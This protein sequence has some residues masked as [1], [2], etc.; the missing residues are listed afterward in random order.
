MKSSDPNPKLPAWIFIA[1]DLALI[2]AAVLIAVASPQPLSGSAVLWIVACV[3]LGAIAGLVPLVII[4]EQ[5]KNELLDDRQRAL[6]ALARTVHSSAEQISIAANGLHQISELALKNLRMAEHLPHKLQEKIAEF[7][8]QLAVAADAEKEELEREL[9]SLRTSESERLESVSQRIAKTTAEWTKLEAASNQHLTAANETATRLGASLAG[10]IAKAQSAAEHALAQARVDAARS[11]GESGGQAVRALEAAKA[12]AMVEFDTK[13]ATAAA[14]VAERISAELATRL[15]ALPAP[16]PAAIAPKSTP[17]VAP[18]EPA[19]EPIVASSPVAAERP[20][21]VVAAEPD[22]SSAPP[23]APEPDAPVSPTPKRPR[24]PRRE[25]P[26]PVAPEAVVTASPGEEPPPVPAEAIPEITPIAPPTAEPFSG[27]IATVPP[28][29]PPAPAVESVRPPANTASPARES[30][31]RN[32]RVEPVD[33][34]PALGLGLEETSGGSV[35]EGVLTSDGATRLLVTA[36]IGIGNRLFIRGNGPGLSWDKG[37][38]LQ[39][40]S[41]GK[42]RWETNDA[43]APVRFKLYKNDAVECAALGE[44]SVEPGHQQEVTAAF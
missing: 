29:S 26:P 30:R 21:A 3:G 44:Q 15:A 11:I 34:E 31:R 25:T 19:P 39:F 13:I 12:A 17:V 27:H 10:A 37:V 35:A 2:G 38:P 32:E 18:A 14:L 8:S 7:Q 4:Y 1:T 41:I 6:E 40:V 28:P 33:E 43:S 42:W 5:R 20:G 24:R 9:L 16:A 23:V 22:T 36:Y